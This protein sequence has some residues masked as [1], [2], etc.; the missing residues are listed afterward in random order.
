MPAFACPACGATYRVPES[1]IGRQ[2]KCARCAHQWRAA[3]GQVI[4]PFGRA[5][6]AF[7]TASPGVPAAVASPPGPPP[8]TVA[9]VTPPSEP[10]R[11]AAPDDDDILSRAFDD[12][13]RRAA[14]STPRVSDEDGGGSGGVR[15]T[16]PLR[17]GAPMAALSEGGRRPSRGGVALAFA[18]AG[19]L[20][21]LAGGAYALAVYRASVAE[22]WPPFQRVAGWFGG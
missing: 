18:W 1:A 17:V 22:A 8:A 14:K 16:G 19:S 5:V 20:A 9:T 4:S 12:A 10:A 15:V 21:T 13:P 3:A 11:S 7:A 2:L 6:E